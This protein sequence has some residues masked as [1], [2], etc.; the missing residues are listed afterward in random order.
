ML[1]VYVV[2]SIYRRVVVVV[3]ANVTAS[4]VSASVT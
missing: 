3:G 2:N 4:P 1:T